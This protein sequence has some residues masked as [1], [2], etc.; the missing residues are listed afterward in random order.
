MLCSLPRLEALA[1]VAFAFAFVA[2]ARE[3]NQAL[4][5]NIP[6]RYGTTLLDMNFFQSRQHVFHSR[7]RVRVS[8]GIVVVLVL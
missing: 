7:I 8:I 3:C 1:A 6:C 2:A 5:D 4:F